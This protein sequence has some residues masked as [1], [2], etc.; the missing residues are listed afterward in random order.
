MDKYVYREHQVVTSYLYSVH[1]PR[2]IFF[3]IG[4]STL[5][6]DKYIWE[7]QGRKFNSLGIPEAELLLSENS[8]T[9]E[10]RSRD[11]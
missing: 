10:I 11:L 9:P 4:T 1:P 8:V 5:K 6:L 7:L 2:Y 3:M